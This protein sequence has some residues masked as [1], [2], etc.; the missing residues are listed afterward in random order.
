[1]AKHSWQFLQR[2]K[3]YIFYYRRRIPEHLRANFNNQWEIKRS[4]KTRDKSLA[5]LRHNQFNLKVESILDYLQKGG[6]M[7]GDAINTALI[8][9][10]QKDVIARN[11]EGDTDAI[12]SGV[13]MALR[14]AILPTP[15]GRAIA[16]A[17]IKIVG[18]KLLRVDGTEVNELHI[19]LALSIADSLGI[20][21]LVDEK[22]FNP[23]PAKISPA[24]ETPMS[25]KIRE[26]KAQK[27]IVDKQIE[28][29]LK[30]CPEEAL[31]V[32]KEIEQE[33]KPIN[34]PVKVKADKKGLIPIR[35]SL[36]IQDSFKANPSLQSRTIKANM[37]IFNIFIEFYGDM[38][39]TDIGHVEVN[40]FFKKIQKIPSN[41]SKKYPNISFT[42][43]IRKDIP[44]DQLL[45]AVSVNKYMGR[46]SNLFAYGVSRG[47]MDKN[48]AD[49]IRVKVNKK[50]TIKKKKKPFSAQDLVDY[51]NAPIHAENKRY[52]KYQ[53][54]FWLPLIALYSGMR[55]EEIAQLQI[56]DV[57]EIEDDHSGAKAWCFD[58]NEDGIG[59]KHLKNATSI[60]IV[61]IHTELI[62]MGFMDYFH[63]RRRG[64]FQTLWNL[65]KSAGRGYAHNIERRLMRYMRDKAGITDTQKTFHSFRH[66]VIQ[67]LRNNHEVKKGYREALVGHSMTGT[68]DNSYFD[69]LGIIPLKS[70][71]EYIKYPKLDLSHLYVD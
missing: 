4:L 51:F 47:H 28:Q 48:Y 71:I 5:M 43:I 7:T 25:K 17:P 18:N 34:E 35:F 66:T 52:K 33:I 26:L 56:S 14:G 16:A 69:G 54:M 37:A 32:K 68:S 57:R 12:M 61:P 70:T 40:D 62:K 10:A 2:S 27:S 29:R 55:I 11:Q 50:A 3:E 6:Y 15:K 31:E 1:M 38:L 39:S 42:E 60:R 59:E 58:L 44:Q 8:I 49:G 13:V 63:E 64:S 46:L 53:E 45:S 67:T 30:E 23:N 21:K 9:D 24:K 20:P 36:M 19:S 22:P 41:I 65:K